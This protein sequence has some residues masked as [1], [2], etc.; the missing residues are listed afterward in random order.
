M[1]AGV[2][3]SDVETKRAG[4]RLFRR[5]ADRWVDLRVKPDLPV[6]KVKA[7]SRSYFTLV[8]KLP[9]LREA[10]ALGEQV[11]V[12]GRS[13][14]IEVVDDARE[15]TDTEVQTIIRGF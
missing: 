12:A 2:G 5:Q 10:L 9:E 7:Y 1:A 14:T 15:L 6:Y 11:T 4:A 13:V 3:E 8:E